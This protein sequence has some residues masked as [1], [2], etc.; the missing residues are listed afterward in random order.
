MPRTNFCIP[1]DQLNIAEDIRKRYGNMLTARDVGAVIG[2]A[3]YKSINK[4]LEG[5]PCFEINNRR[6]YSAA[7]VAR[8]L[9]EARSI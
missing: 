7:D 1:T 3:H 4:W 8:K 6:R 5:L 2:V 9:Y